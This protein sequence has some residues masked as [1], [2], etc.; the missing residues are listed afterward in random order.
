MPSFKLPCRWRMWK[1]QESLLWHMRLRWPAC[2]CLVELRLCALLPAIL[3]PSSSKLICRWKWITVE[4]WKQYCS[5]IKMPS[6]HKI[7]V[8]YAHLFIFHSWLNFSTIILQSHDEQGDEQWGEDQAAE[9]VMQQPP[10]VV[11]G[12]YVWQGHWPPYV[13]SLCGQQGPGICTTFV[14]AILTPH[15]FD[16]IS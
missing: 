4:F 2:T 1:M 16:L 13:W 6:F 5:L 15:L 9:E 12:C 7:Y 10:G 14:I 11:Q 3:L 8:N